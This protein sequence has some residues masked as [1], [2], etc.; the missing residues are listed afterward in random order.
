M[1]QTIDRPGLFHDTM[2]LNGEPFNP[3][4]YPPPARRR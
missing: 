3:D 4:D 1:R 2:T